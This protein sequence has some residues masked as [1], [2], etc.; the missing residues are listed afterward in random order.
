[1]TAA[2]TLETVHMESGM[3]YQSGSDR[4]WVSRRRVTLRM[5]LSRHFGTDS[6][7]GLGE[8]AGGC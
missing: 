2:E 5:T 4:G 1:V 6:E 3:R 7:H 8:K